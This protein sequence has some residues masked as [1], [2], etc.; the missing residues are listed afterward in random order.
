MHWHAVA[1]AVVYGM[2]SVSSTMWCLA[3]FRR[4]WTG[5]R[6]WSQRAGRASY[7]T[8]LLHPL[9]LTTALVGLSW[10]PGSPE[11]KFLLAAILGVP[12]CFVIG[13]TITRLPGTSHVL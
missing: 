8:Y 12:I 4:R 13:Y 10:A 2:V 7:A 9:V 3:W 6:P 1:F 11:A 5:H